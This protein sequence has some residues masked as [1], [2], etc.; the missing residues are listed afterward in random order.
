MERKPA[1]VLM[2]RGYDNSAFTGSSPGETAN[3]HF[4][5]SVYLSDVSGDSLLELIVRRRLPPTAACPR[6]RA[7]SSAAR[8]PATASAGSCAKLARLRADGGSC[9]L[10]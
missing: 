4:G 6:E 9:A 3:D 7:T 5:A 2:R 1:R 8:R 10:S